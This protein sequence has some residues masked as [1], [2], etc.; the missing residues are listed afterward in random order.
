MY[1]NFFPVRD[2]LSADGYTNTLAT[3]I[4]LSRILEHVHTKTMGVT[5]NVGC[6]SKIQQ[7]LSA[8]S[9]QMKQLAPYFEQREKRRTE[10][11]VKAFALRAQK[12]TWCR[13]VEQAHVLPPRC[14]ES[15]G[16]EV[17]YHC[18]RR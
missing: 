11:A 8:L 2:S 13:R 12:G 18:W 9:K 17:G 6:L 15:S 1:H 14:S 10:V 5:E 3:S 7:Q 16:E 4:Y